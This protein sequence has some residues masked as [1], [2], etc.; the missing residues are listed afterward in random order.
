[1][2]QSLKKESQTKDLLNE[3]I[4]QKFD[5][6]F[7]DVASIKP[8]DEIIFTSE[9]KEDN[10]MS[11]GSKKAKSEEHQPDIDLNFDID[12]DSFELD[13][14]TAK[15]EEVDH[16]NSQSKLSVVEDDSELE[17][18]FNTADDESMNSASTQL[19]NENNKKADG[20]A[21]PHFD[22]VKDDEDDFL[23]GIK[24]DDFIVNEDKT[25]KTILINS[26][27]L[28]E[29]KSQEH[30][31]EKKSDKNESSSFVAE[32]FDAS[33]D[34]NSFTLDELSEKQGTVEIMS[35][36]EANANIEK[37]I[38]DILKPKKMEATQEF[39]LSDVLSDDSDLGGLNFD[40]VDEEINVSDA[41]NFQPDPVKKPN[42]VAEKKLIE[43]EV[44]KVDNS[45]TDMQFSNDEAEPSVEMTFND[46]EKPEDNNLEREEIPAITAIT[47]LPSTPRPQ[48]ISNERSSF[49][50]DDESIRVQA[51]MR[52]LR[53]ERE[54]FLNQI[55]AIKIENKELE[56]DNLTLKAAF[57]EAKIEISILRKR[58][59]VE[60]EDLKYQL[61]LKEEKKTLAEER[62][63]IAENK[64]EKL[65]QK[66]RID[67]N[68]VKQREKE[69][70]SKLE[71]LS[72]DV[73]SQVHTRDQKILELR[74]K[75]DALEFNMENVSIRELKSHED[76][77][78]LEDKLTKIMKTLRHS[79][80][81]LEDDIDL[82]SEEGH[83]ERRDKNRL[84]K[85]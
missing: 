71:M 68:Q 14:L 4:Q 35:P 2:G 23:T 28:K 20:L 47:S 10:S 29:I 59:S 66:V 77:R 67:F 62:A 36:E 25:Q 45:L 61:S 43:A 82:V 16:K 63:K 65:E 38:F 80:K 74:R 52:Q 70:E 6:V 30:E 73:D 46:E 31:V 32:A 60:M 27:Q 72:I 19:T 12:N 13:T 79:I 8:T 42:P 84:G 75:I 54:D 48:S 55:K 76:K 51:T 50:S 40:A 57:D 1:M 39:D 9:S 24:A 33:E 83:D 11:E 49:I 21:V 56:Q 15:S 18:A 44:V 58:H 5:L 3:K 37:T 22:E 69:L 34:S 26:A 85:A 64:R 7:K 17:F 81:N 78:K 41:F 53:E